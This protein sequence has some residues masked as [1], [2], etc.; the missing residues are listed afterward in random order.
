MHCGLTEL[1]LE[2][3]KEKII[4]ESASLSLDE[5]QRIAFA[6][7]LYAEKYGKVIHC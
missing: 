4:L 6:R 3:D 5:R 1:E 7:A 2:M